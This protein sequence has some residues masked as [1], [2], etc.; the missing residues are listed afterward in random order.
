MRERRG[1]SEGFKRLVLLEHLAVLIIVYFHP[2][3]FC[4]HFPN[5]RKFG[6][7]LRVS[8][9]VGLHELTDSVI[10][11]NRFYTFKAIS[12]RRERR[13]LSEGFKRLVL[14]EHLAVLKRV[15]TKI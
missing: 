13:G 9:F 10:A 3:F 6:T 1:L 14:L 7:D 12:G 4:P 8:F 2:L 11:M 5:F 15:G